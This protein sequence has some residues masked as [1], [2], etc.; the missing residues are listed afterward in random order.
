MSSTTILDFF[1]WCCLPCRHTRNTHLQWHSECSPSRWTLHHRQAHSEASLDS[2]RTSSNHR[3]WA[4]CWILAEKKGC[5]D[6]CRILKKA[7]CVWGWFHRSFSSQWVYSHQIV[8]KQLTTTPPLG[9]N[10]SFVTWTK[11]RLS[12]WRKP[13][14]P[15]TETGSTKPKA[16]QSCLKPKG[17]QLRSPGMSN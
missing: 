9:G 14:P 17:L 12:T 13:F 6:D 8:D 7:I 15:S 4:F 2:R 11:L 1:V 3:C 5:Q 16:K 10:W